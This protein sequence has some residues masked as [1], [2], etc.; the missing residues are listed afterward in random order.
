MQTK[1]EL[2]DRVEAHKHE[3]ASKLHD[4]KA[5]V[6]KEARARRE[7]LQKQLDE[8]A[9]HLK[10]GWEKVDSAARSKLDKWLGSR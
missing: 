5:D 7:Q 2:R 8:L 10:D 4:L 6:S 3:L 9:S 1:D